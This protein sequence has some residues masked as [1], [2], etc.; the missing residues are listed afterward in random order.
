MFFKIIKYFF[1]L[2]LCIQV[3]NAF[4]EEILICQSCGIPLTIETSK[5]SKIIYGTEADGS[6]NKEYCHFCYEKG[7]FTIEATLDEYIEVCIPYVISKDLSEEAARKMFK[8]ELVKLKR[9]KK[10]N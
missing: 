4:A 2:A 3:I 1:V 9:W 8:K 10:T 7:K 6:V 5:G